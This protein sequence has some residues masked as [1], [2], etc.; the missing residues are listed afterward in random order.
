ML[1]CRRLA[2]AVHV[3]KR[4]T[5]SNGQSADGRV[6]ARSRPHV[7]YQSQTH[8]TATGSSEIA[9]GDHP[10]CLQ[11]VDGSLSAADIHLDDDRGASTMIQRIEKV[12]SQSIDPVVE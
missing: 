7:F 9:G 3:K 2:L 8:W 11:P 10:S 5:T 12:H 1:V 4:N 6:T